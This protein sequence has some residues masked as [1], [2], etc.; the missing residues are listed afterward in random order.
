MKNSGRN[1]K[2]NLLAEDRAISA[3]VE[4]YKAEH[5][6]TLGLVIASHF[7][8]DGLRILKTFYGALE[9]ANFHAEA[10]IVSSMICQLG[11]E[12]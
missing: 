1:K 6:E 10:A 2:L 4:G 5:C 7:Q 9:D 3:F 11:G 8:W 12:E